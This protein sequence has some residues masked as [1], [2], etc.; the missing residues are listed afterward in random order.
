MVLNLHIVHMNLQELLRQ[1]DF[2]FHLEAGQGMTTMATVI[3]SRSELNSVRL[4]EQLSLGGVEGGA[5]RVPVSQTF[6]PAGLYRVCLRACQP[7][8]LP[9]IVN[10]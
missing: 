1:S 7:P 5:E 3:V 8:F 4:K 10:W 9:P 2:L 6:F